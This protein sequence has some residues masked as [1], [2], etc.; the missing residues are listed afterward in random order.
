M[1]GIPNGQ[2]DVD[3]GA[4]ASLTASYQLV[5]A[6]YFRAM[7]IALLRGRNFEDADGPN[8]DHVVIVNETLAREAWPGQDPIGKRITGGGMDNF[9]QERKRATVVGVVASVR[10]SELSEPA[11]A[12]LYFP[13]QQRPFRAWEMTAA[14]R[15]V[16]GEA[17]ALASVVREAVRG[18]DADVPVRM[19]TIDEQLSGSLA[20][21]RFLLLL[22]GAFAAIALLLGTVGVYGIVSY[23]VQRRRREIGIRIA[24]GALPGAVRRQVQRDYLIA[25]AAGAAAGLLLSIAL[26]RSLGALLFEVRP[27]DPLTL[28]AVLVLLGTVS[29]TASFVPSRKGTRMD[30]L[31]TM[32]AE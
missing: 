26:T 15:Q 28:V 11:E 19:T 8:A 9:W 30:P 12:T 27:T 29:W 6:G 16:A 1:V 24:L 10:Q 31:E 7:D 32:R 21:R 20:P 14:L 2:V 22:V 4:V 5:S 23:A 18:I 13:Y 3:N 17:S 25:G